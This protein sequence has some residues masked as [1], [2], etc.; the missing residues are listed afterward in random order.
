MSLLDYEVE[1][2]S[3]Q[4]EHSKQGGEGSIQ[5]RGKHVLQGQDRPL[6]SVSDGSEEGLYGALE[7]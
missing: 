3:C 2:R 5:N 6:I 7:S 4:H 1:L